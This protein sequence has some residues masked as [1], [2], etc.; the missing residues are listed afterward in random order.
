MLMCLDLWAPCFF[1]FSFVHC[2]WRWF[3][4]GSLD[5]C[6]KTLVHWNASILR[7]KLQEG[8]P[9]SLQW[10]GQQ[11][12][13][14]NFNSIE[15]H[16]CGSSVL[17]TGTSLAWWNVNWMNCNL[18]LL[19]PCALGVRRAAIVLRSVS[20]CVTVFFFSSCCFNGLGNSIWI[21]VDDAWCFGNVYLVYQAADFEEG[22]R[23]EYV[24]WRSEVGEV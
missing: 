18:R 23:V 6:T 3:A 2:T 14:I 19:V 11:A 22:Y 5:P 12:K 15:K 9:K 13:G 21:H 4:D 16:P 1:T 8:V 17:S 10:K 24:E 7:S 20:W